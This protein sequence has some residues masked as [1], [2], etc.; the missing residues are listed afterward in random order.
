VTARFP[1]RPVYDTAVTHALLRRVA[2]GERPETLRL[3]VPDD[4][5][6]FSILD[7]RRPGFEEAL[8]AGARLGCGA[9]I[10]LAGGHAALFHEQCLAFSWAMPDLR[11]RDGIAR[12]FEAVSEWLARA[13]VRLGVDARVG[14]VPGEYCPG[15][16]SVNARG[17]V[18][19][20]GVGQ[21]VIRGGAHVGGVIVV[22]DAARVRSVLGPVYDAL[23]L[24]WDSATAGAV[25]D[26]VPGVGPEQVREAAL[27]ELDPSRDWRAAEIDDATRR[28]A[29]EL[30]AWHDP[31]GAARSGHGETPRAKLVVARDEPPG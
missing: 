5:V 1:G 28:L 31:A 20:M 10:R 12:R 30:A 22:R 27:A 19:L 17:R 13:L 3:Y 24:E 16:H 14:E 7:T 8:E 2:A 4:T 15:E 25:E 18:K 23:G 11:E 29:D 21:R 9:V 26:E 6:V